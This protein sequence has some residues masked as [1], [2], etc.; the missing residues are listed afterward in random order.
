MRIRAVFLDF[1]DT[2][3]DRDAYVYPHYRQLLEQH[4]RFANA[5]EEEA[6]LQQVMLWDELG[7][8]PKHTIQQN[9]AQR[10]GIQ[11]PFDMDAWWATIDYSNAV[12]LPDVEA[13][14]Q[15]LRDKGYRLGLIT[16]GI[17]RTQ[18][19][20]VQVTGVDRYL[21]DVIVSGDLPYGKPDVR[22]YQLAMSHLQVEPQEAVMVGDT[23]M[24]DIIGALR[25]GM[26][27]VWV[28]SRTRRPSQTRVRRIA[29]LGELE[30]ALAE[31]EAE[32]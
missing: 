4:A 26:H 11:I 28:Q 31:L 17:S 8:S 2:L 1:D 27:A 5:E 30:A 32:N 24:T 23:F 6:V 13:V 15:R 16:N 19:Q 21:D 10:Y 9:L 7:N 29:G 25:A 20:K 22:I 14:L 18:H 12:L 3:G